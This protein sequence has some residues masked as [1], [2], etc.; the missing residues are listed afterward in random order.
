MSSKTL[1]NASELTRQVDSAM[2]KHVT[3]ATQEIDAGR[4]AAGMEPLAVGGMIE[5]VRTGLGSS[6]QKY[7]EA[8]DFVTTEN[9]EDNEKRQ[10]RDQRRD[11]LMGS[12]SSLASAIELC[13]GRAAV[14]QLGLA[15]TTPVSP[16][17]LI[18]MVK[19]FLAK[20][21]DGIPDLGQPKKTWNVPDLVKAR[22]ECEALAGGLTTSID[23]LAG[24]LRE[25]EKARDD[26]DIAMDRWH[27]D[28]RFAA[29]L[30]RAVLRRAGRDELAKKVLPSAQ[31]I[32]HL[33]PTEI[34]EEPGEGGEG[35][36]Q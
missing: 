23:D 35:G 2:S 11:D 28:L 14:I 34:V 21:K 5:L 20:T 33:A 15:G 31:A 18:T 12:V 10:I 22:Q 8:E 32:D 1:E 29:D 7:D 6:F 19:G 26:R 24:D 27:R 3:P 4:S 9:A 36:D 25:T 30:S 17:P 13:W 16:K